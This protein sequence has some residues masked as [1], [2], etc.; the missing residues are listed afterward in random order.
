MRLVV[1]ALSTVLF[2]FTAASS[3]AD[4]VART[5]RL[6]RTMLFAMLLGVSLLALLAKPLIRV[7][8]GEAFLPAASSLY[9]MAP[10]IAVWPFGHFLGVHLAASGRPRI[11]FLCSIATGIVAG[12]ACKLLI[13]AF[14]ATGAGAA[15]SVI[16]V[17]QSVLRSFAYLRAG[18]TRVTEVLVCTPKDMTALLNLLAW[19]RRRQGS[20]GNDNA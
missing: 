1:N 3:E 7:L 8:Y 18:G 5:N 10:G 15:V 20:R 17:T 2:P 11:V 14:A 12:V 4:A 19:P 16:F 6:C 13:P 9:A